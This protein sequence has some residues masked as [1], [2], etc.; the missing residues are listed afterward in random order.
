MK[1]AGITCLLFST[2]L[3][4]SLVIDIA[5]GFNV[6]DAV[7]NTLNPFRVMDTGEMAVIGVFILVL[8]ADLMMAFIRKRKEG[9]GKKKGR[10]K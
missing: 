10:M 8:A 6:N 9:A 5:L 7:R 1:T 4:F 2:L 3:G